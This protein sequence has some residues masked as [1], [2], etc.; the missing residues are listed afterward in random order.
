MREEGGATGAV[1]EEGGATGAVGE[2]GG[3]TGAVGEL[4]E[5]REGLLGT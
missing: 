4:C 1:G 3:A 5:K 2:E